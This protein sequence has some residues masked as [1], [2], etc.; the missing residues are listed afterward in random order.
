[1]KTNTIS[2]FFILFAIV[3]T[4]ST[5]PSAFAAEVSVPEGTGVPG[6][7][8]TNECWIPN[9]INIAVGE[10][11]TWTNDDTAA[12]T[13][14]SGSPADGPDQIFDSSLFMAGTSF[15][16]TFD[17]EGTF[18]YFCMVHPWMQGTVIVG[19]AMAEEPMAPES[20]MISIEADP[21]SAGET[22]TINVLITGSDGSAVEHANIDITA[23]QGNNQVLD[24]TNVHTADHAGSFTFTTSALDA[25]AS[26]DNPVD[27]D[28]TFKGFG[29][30]QPFTGPIGEEMT[31][32][33]VPEFG[34]I[35]M[36]ILAVGVVSIIAFT[37]KTKLIP[38]L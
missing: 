4:L 3:A 2:S 21:V 30:N 15:S 14:S 10:T 25:D 9:D 29:I 11:V 32:Q 36:M 35:A 6:C 27:V 1:M 31:A 7:E 28:V 23:T 38:R 13:V 8:D 17:T 22:M 26:G 37:A 12:H 34:T 24:K 5:I 33:V 19:A 20:V 18:D 16:H